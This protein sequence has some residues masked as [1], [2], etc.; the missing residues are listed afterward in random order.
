MH[1]VIF[2]KNYFSRI[3][4]LYF[5]SHLPLKKEESSSSESDADVNII[6][7]HFHGRLGERFFNH[8]PLR[9]TVLMTCGD[10]EWRKGSPLL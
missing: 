8:D 9:P 3:C 6:Y 4:T 1:T 10:P 5:G 7:I 2:K